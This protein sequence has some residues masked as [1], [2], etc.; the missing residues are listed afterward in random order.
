MSLLLQRPEKVKQQATTVQIEKST[1]PLPGDGHQPLPWRYP[2]RAIAVRLFLTCWIIYTLHFATNIS[3]EIYPAL[4]LGDDLSFRLDEYANMHPDLF[5]KPGY[6]WHIGNNP[7]VSM[8]AAIPYSLARPIIDPIVARVNASRAASGLTEP[9]E[10][11][12]PWP[13]AQEFYAEA[14]RRGYDVKFGLAAFVMQAFA[15]AP[16]T[17]LGVVAMFFLLR[18]IFNSDK[19]AFW[20]SLLYAFG[21]PVFFR[22]G[23]LNQNLMLGHIAF[24]G[25][26]TM[27]NLA[28][29]QRWSSRTRYFLGGLAGG[30]AVLFDY[31]GLVLLL[32]LFVYGL[33]KRIQ[34]PAPGVSGPVPR[35]SQ[36]N[37]KDLVQ[38]GVWYV[39][40]TLAPIGLLWFYQWQSFGNP[41]LPGQHWMPPVEWI[42][43]GY[44]GYGLPQPE[45]F[46]ML[47]F[48]FRFGL[49]VAS[50]LM[51][52]ALVA[53]WM[54]RGL[55]R[56]LP[57]LE[58]WFIL[59]LFLAFWLFFSGS[60][61][62]R[63]QFN[64]GIRYLTPMFP[65]L[66]VPVAVVLVRLPRHAILF[67]A[68][69]SVAESWSLAMHRDVER[70]YGMLDPILHVFIGGF[71]L[72]I[73][74]TISR[75]GAQLGEHVA[76]GVSP[77]P[78]FA[79]AAAVIFA[80]WYP[81]RREVSTP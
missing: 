49:F 22:T 36:V 30:T 47:G 58:L 18:R 69:A 6:G 50:P 20:L 8:V 25:F 24:A 7:G 54:D 1:A 46:L 14:W 70:G 52:L 9:P 56:R 29:S 72:P 16:S 17:A 21:T 53:P 4:G 23:Y 40:G 37:I 13:M 27:W 60:N 5:E 78:L 80:I 51:L 33:I 45:L 74:T 10:F 26:V 39:L 63:L 68:V 81:R 2:P 76:N 48:D 41:F 44:Q 67:I 28:D 34:R 62:T 75:M 55:G 59:A 42:E 77:L 31:S 57:R 32:G 35:F 38:H 66:F 11:T 79:L 15:M 12:S 65:F 71:K 61:Y 19:T 64:T 43:L 3:R 73:L